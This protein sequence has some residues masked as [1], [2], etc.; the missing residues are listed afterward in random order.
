MGIKDLP[1][2]KEMQRGVY[3]NRKSQRRGEV[4]NGNITGEFA[5]RKGHCEKK[6]RELKKEA[7]MRGGGGDKIFNRGDYEKGRKCR[8]NSEPQT[9]QGVNTPGRPQQYLVFQKQNN[10]SCRR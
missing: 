10:K 5:G 6:M 2:G 1:G 3:G 8:K 4:A 7:D 9:T